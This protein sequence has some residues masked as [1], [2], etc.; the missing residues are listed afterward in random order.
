M[1]RKVVK[2]YIP[3]QLASTLSFYSEQTGLSMSEILRMALMEYLERNC[4]PAKRIIKNR[5]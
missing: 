3:P 5:A 2:T 1:P 4:P